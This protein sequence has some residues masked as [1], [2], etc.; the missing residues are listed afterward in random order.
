MGVG[1]S[2]RSA[3]CEIRNSKPKRKMK[4]EKEEKKRRP[5]IRAT[6]SCTGTIFSGKQGGGDF[7]VPFVAKLRKTK[8]AGAWGGGRKILQPFSGREN[9]S[10]CETKAPFLLP[11]PTPFFAE[12]NEPAGFFPGRRGRKGGGGGNSAAFQP[13]RVKAQSN[14]RPRSSPWVG[15]SCLLSPNFALPPSNFPPAKV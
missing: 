10:L 11:F 1:H 5:E 9:P 6:I 4:L 2:R 13:E 7:M 12:A 14:N 15:R 8:A 3:V